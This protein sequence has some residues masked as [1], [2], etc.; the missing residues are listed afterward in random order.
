MKTYQALRNVGGFL[1]FYGVTV[2]ILAPLIGVFLM[3]GDYLAAGILTI[4]IGLPSGA[5]LLGIGEAFILLTDIARAVQSTPPETI[6]R[7]PPQLEK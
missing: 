6:R 4:V 7:L 5:F 3:V 2:L 1:S